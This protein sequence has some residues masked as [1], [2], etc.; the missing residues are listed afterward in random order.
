MQHGYVLLITTFQI[1]TCK[2][3]LVIVVLSA[4]LKRIP[5]QYCI[6]LHV[7]NYGYDIYAAVKMPRDV[8]FY[9]PH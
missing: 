5:D 1:L 4:F 8:K 9:L 3:E 7:R 2:R 6:L